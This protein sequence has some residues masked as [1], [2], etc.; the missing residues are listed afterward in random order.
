MGVFKQEPT[1]VLPQ[2]GAGTE[3]I[4]DLLTHPSI[5]IELMRYQEK[6]VH[7]YCTE[8]VAAGVPPNLQFWIE[9]A[10]ANAA[11]FYGILGVPT[12]VV[13]TGVN[14]AAQVITLPWTAHSDW[15]RVVAQALA[16]VAGAS[17]TVVAYYSAKGEI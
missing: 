8:V 13:G 6:V 5:G 3:A 2:T 16:V 4:T 1:I 12:V 9:T 11:A 15:A 14:G 7:V 17:W 10:P